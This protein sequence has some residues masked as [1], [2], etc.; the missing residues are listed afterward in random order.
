[1]SRKKAI[2]NFCKECI[3]D[4]KQEGT[5]RGQVENCTATNCPLYN[6]RPIS[7]KKTLTLNK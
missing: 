4:K 6:Y 1:M 3:Y 5:W 2:D 7:I